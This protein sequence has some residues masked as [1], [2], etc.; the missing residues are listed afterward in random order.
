VARQKIT[1][2]STAEYFSKNLQQVGFSSPTKAVLT[3]LKEAV[4]NSLDACE[5]EGIAP[6]IVVEIEKLGPGTMKNTDLIRI[7]VED[8][9]PGLDPDDVPKVFG[10]YLASSKFGRG[11]CS[12]GQQGIGISAATTWAQ[13]TS[14]KGAHVITKTKNMR[15]AQ[16]LVVEVDIKNNRGIVKERAAIPWTKPSGVSVEFLI[17]GRLQIHGDGGLLTYLQGTSLVNP[18]LSLRYKLADMDWVD[19]PRVSTKVPE[20]PAAVEPHPH[21]MKLGEFIAHSHLFGRVTLES[22]LKKGFS[23]VTDNT[24]QEFVKNGLDKKL[25]ETSVDK[26]TDTQFKAIY[27]AIQK[28]ELMAPSTKS[29]MTIGEEAFSKSIRRLG[30]IDFFAVVTRKPTIC[31]SKPVVVEVAM[32]RL[33][34]PPK[35]NEGEDE[36]PVTV[37]RFANRVPLQFDK[38]ACAMVHSIETVNWRAYGLAQARDSLPLGPYVIAVSLVSPFIKF[39]NASKETVDASDELVEEMRRA[40]MQVGQRLSRHIRKESREADL[41]EKLR[42]IEQFGPILVDGLCRIVGAPDTRRKKAM[43]GLER[44]LGRDVN[45]AKKELKEAV[46]EARIAAA[47]GK[48]QII[49]KDAEKAIQDE[50]ADKDVIEAVEV[51]KQIEK[52]GKH[53][54]TAPKTTP[55]IEKGK[56]VAEA[57]V[58]EAARGAGKATTAKLAKKPAAKAIARKKEKG[59]EA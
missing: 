18:H 51:E 46:E 13:L 30:D 23:R 19:L 32:A 57:L 33:S 16:S 20:I 37:L 53:R 52:R 4:D 58:P 27:S 35:R 1:S 41:E 9:G 10:E 12:R 45:A 28:T 29:V 34:S 17:D 36:S 3:T 6:E 39:K 31:D 14:G 22:W 24:I 21:T 38:A 5:D 40:L 47:K 44:L 49:D 11:R 55:R 25:L 2:S 48:L 26:I 42:H 59:V 56:K 7:K 54:G 43:E 15:Q 8:N 50:S